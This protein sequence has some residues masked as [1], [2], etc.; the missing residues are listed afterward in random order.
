MRK[1][2]YIIGNGFDKHHSIPCGYQDYR[3][4]LKSSSNYLILETI[5]NN[6]GWTDDDWWSKFEENLASVETLRIATEE[7]FEHYPD[8]GS[9]DFRDR[10]W[11]E[12]AISVETRLQ[13]TYDSI[14][15][16]FRCWIQSLPKGNNTKMLKLR[17]GNSLFLNFNYTDTLETI[18]KINPHKILYI[19]GKGDSDDDLIIGHGKSYK[20]IEKDMEKFE[21]IEEGDF[22]YQLAKGAAVYEV[23]QYNKPVDKIITKHKEWFLNLSDVTHIHIY[24]HSFSDVDLPY[25]SKVFASVD[26]SNIQLEVSAFTDEDKKR[27]KTFMHTKNVTFCEN[28]FVSL[29]DLQYSIQTRIEFT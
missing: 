7:A 22:V 3:R 19:H 21:Q 2:L 16:S 5:D 23:S 25:F 20:D 1:D 29:A 15:D 13:S 24:G 28:Q 11:N 27:I 9:D 14:K 26:I 4:W 8:F 12:A 6:F 10:D 18:Y 17:R